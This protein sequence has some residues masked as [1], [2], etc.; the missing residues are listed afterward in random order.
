MTDSLTVSIL[1]FR[2]RV[3]FVP[4]PHHHS[5]QPCE[6]SGE[7]VASSADHITLRIPFG[8]TFERL[9]YPRRA[10]RIGAPSEVCHAKTLHELDC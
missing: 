9:D 2:R 5:M 3:G 8:N 4:A 10:V 6:V 1:P 7:I